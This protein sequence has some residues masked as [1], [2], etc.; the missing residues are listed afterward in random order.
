MKYFIV[1]EKK[2]N[3]FFFAFLCV[4]S[5]CT[6]CYHSF[7]FY[8][9]IL[10][11]EIVIV[12]VAPSGYAYRLIY[13]SGSLISKIKMRKIDFFFK[14]NNVIELVGTNKSKKKSDK[15]ENPYYFKIMTN[16]K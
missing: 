9:P 15:G 2:I 14:V 3:S 10:L 8:A 16:Q 12:I 11:P 5:L 1:S 13:N 6:Y 7:L 4:A